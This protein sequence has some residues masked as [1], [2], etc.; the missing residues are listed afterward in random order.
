M[1][2]SQK[3]DGLRVCTFEDWRDFRSHY[4]KKTPSHTIFRGQRDP[5]WK[6]QSLWDRKIA[7]ISAVIGHD[8]PIQSV[9]RAGA[10]EA[11]R[12]Q[13]LRHF[14]DR[15][16]QH[17]KNDGPTPQYDAEWWALGRHYGL[18][19]P[20]LDWTRKPLVAAFFAFMDLA[21]W[22]LADDATTQERNERKQHP[23]HVAI[24]ALDCSVDVFRKPEFERV[25]DLPRFEKR[26]RAQEGMFTC[27]SDGRH[28]D[29]QS[30]LSHRDRLGALC[31][32][33]VPTA[34]VRTTLNELHDEDVNYAALFPDFWGAAMYANTRWFVRPE[35]SSQL[36]GDE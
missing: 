3:D 14:K 26:Q 28:F 22:R 7:P 23:P 16:M 18:M 4:D 24:W 29:V 35:S 19:S 25:D 11:N 10:Y 1:Q 36:L 13:S 12:N 9:F 8:K 34:N 17:V 32:C 31:R 2:E 15:A 6:L 5:R 30:Y 21:E 20:W 27:L 33:D